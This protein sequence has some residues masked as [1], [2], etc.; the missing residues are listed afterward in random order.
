MTIIIVKTT[1][2][3]GVIIYLNKLILPLQ[4]GWRKTSVVNLVHGVLTS[5][6]QG[7]TLSSMLMRKATQITPR[8][9]IR[10]YTTTRQG[11]EPIQTQKTCSTVPCH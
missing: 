10:V 8:F 7:A 5:L 9:D 11:I 3:D 6:V 1:C 2:Q 4:T